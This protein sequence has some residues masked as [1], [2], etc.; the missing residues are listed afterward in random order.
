MTSSKDINRLHPNVEALFSLPQNITAHEQRGYAPQIATTENGLSHPFDAGGSIG[1][2][3]CS[4]SCR[5]KP[6]HNR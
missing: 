2:A 1:S 6:V 3:A 5:V 4:S